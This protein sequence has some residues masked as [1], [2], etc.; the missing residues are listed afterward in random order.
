MS[1]ASSKISKNGKKTGLLGILAQL[2]QKEQTEI[3]HLVGQWLNKT[4]A[5]ITTA[6]GSR[7]LNDEFL[8]K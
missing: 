2:P 7:V 8:Q 6:K 1:V 4:P 5:P 3:H